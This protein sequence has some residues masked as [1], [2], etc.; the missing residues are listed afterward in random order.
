MRNEMIGAKLRRSGNFT[1]RRVALSHPQR[2]F[3]FPTFADKMQVLLGRSYFSGTG[4]LGTCSQLVIYTLYRG[5]FLVAGSAL[6]IPESG[7]TK[8]ARKIPLYILNKVAIAE[9]Y[10]SRLLNL[11]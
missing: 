7:A 3:P 10:F 9:F 2:R 1:L 8:V 5:T 6:D 4:L 11:N